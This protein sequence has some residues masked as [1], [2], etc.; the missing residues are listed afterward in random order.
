M[1]CFVSLM[2]SRIFGNTTFIRMYTIY[3]Y[4]YVYWLLSQLGNNSFWRTSHKQEHMVFDFSTRSVSSSLDGCASLH[5]AVRVCVWLC[6]IELTL[7]FSR[8]HIALLELV[9][10]KLSPIHS[11]ST[12]CMPCDKYEYDWP[13][14]AVENE[15]TILDDEYILRKMKRHR[16]Q[17]CSLY[18]ISLHTCVCERWHRTET[19]GDCGSDVT[20]IK[21]ST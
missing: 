19:F 2:Q 5:S 21:I 9:S 7:P 8:I 11:E 14:C 10:W 20:R 16:T 6:V 12:Q 4:I 17:L 3:E 18:S 15:L 1:C 13:E